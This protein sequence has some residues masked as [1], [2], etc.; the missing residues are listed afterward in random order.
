VYCSCM[1]SINI[2]ISTEAHARLSSLKK[3]GQSFSDVI[4]E[5]VYPPP[6]K[7]A[8]EFLDALREE[9]PPYPNLEKLEEIRSTRGKRSTRPSK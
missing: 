5:H 9:P 8:G 6:A 3:E 1:P 7:N 4:L 2:T